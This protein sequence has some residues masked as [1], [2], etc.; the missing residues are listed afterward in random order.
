MKSADY[1]FFVSSD[2]FRCGGKNDPPVYLKSL[3]CIPG[4]KYTFLMRTSTYV[5]N[6]TY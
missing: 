1:V 2:L 5:I 6:S 3:A 4:F